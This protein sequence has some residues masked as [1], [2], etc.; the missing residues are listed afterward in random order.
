MDNNNNNNNNNNLY[1]P[2]QLTKLCSNVI[3]KNLYDKNKYIFIR[4]IKTL[5]LPDI[6]N[7]IILDRYQ[8]IK[9]IINHN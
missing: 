6:L 5:E 1:T 8:I 2:L 9:H 3:V 4:N 7:E